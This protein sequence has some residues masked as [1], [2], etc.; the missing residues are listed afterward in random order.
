MHTPNFTLVK[1]YMYGIQCSKH[2]NGY[3]GK[4]VY[5]DIQK[6]PVISIILVL[7]VVPFHPGVHP[8]HV[9]ICM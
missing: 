2:H 5:R 8:K 6:K 4:F 7:H 3:Q 9:P 1:S